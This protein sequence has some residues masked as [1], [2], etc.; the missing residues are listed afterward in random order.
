MVEVIVLPFYKGSQKELL[1]TPTE[2]VDRNKAA[3]TDFQKL[4]LTG[5]TMTDEDYRFF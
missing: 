2:K 5:P 4:L 3:L 1:D